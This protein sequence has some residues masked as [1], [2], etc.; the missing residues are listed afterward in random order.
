MLSPWFCFTYF[1]QHLNGRWCRP[2]EESRAVAEK[3]QD[4]V[5]KFILF[6]VHA[7]HQHQHLK[8]DTIQIVLTHAHIVVQ[9]SDYSDASLL[10]LMALCHHGFSRWSIRLEFCGS[11]RWSSIY[12]RTARHSICNLFLATD[13]RTPPFHHNCPVDLPTSWCSPWHDLW[14]R[15]YV[16]LVGHLSISIQTWTWICGFPTVL[17]SI[18]RLRNVHEHYI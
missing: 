18:C 5:V 10:W 9:K 3:P 12:G 7:Q 2:I 8:S 1:S 6:P 13:W 11:H 14:T 4:A 15:F 17:P 16:R